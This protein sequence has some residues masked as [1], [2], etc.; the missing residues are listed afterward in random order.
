MGKINLSI[1][2]EAVG[3]DLVWNSKDRVYEAVYPRRLAAIER[4]I[5]RDRLA[6]LDKPPA[7]NP[8][9]L[10]KPTRVKV[11]RAFCVARARVEP[12][13]VVTLPRADADSLVAIGK[14]Q[15]VSG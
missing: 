7:P 15:L 14:A 13:E 12:G 1:P 8:P 4:E 9:E 10:L 11:L 5:E 2:S 6:I 3:N